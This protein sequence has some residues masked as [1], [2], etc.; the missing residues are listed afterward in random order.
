VF[1]FENVITRQRPICAEPT[2]CG[3]SGFIDASPGDGVN[4]SKQ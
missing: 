1:G 2:A 3:S 4:W